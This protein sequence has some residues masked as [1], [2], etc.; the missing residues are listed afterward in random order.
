MRD[1][2][3]GLFATAA[4]VRI[5]VA[6]VADRRAVLQYLPKH[7]KVTGKKITGIWLH[8][9]YPLSRLPIPPDRCHICN[10]EYYFPMGTRLKTGEFC[11]GI[12]PSGHFAKLYQ[13][14][15][16]KPRRLHDVQPAF[17][18]PKAPW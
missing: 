3:D 1:D 16:R 5:I 7:T 14:L 10:L 9:E 4:A 8:T 13:F 18:C 2:G 11:M 17:L 12:T 15:V 6:T